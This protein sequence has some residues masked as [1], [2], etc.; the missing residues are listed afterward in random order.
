MK[1][2]IACF[3]ILILALLMSGCG[4][5]L[6]SSIAAD[7]SNEACL[8]E[9]SNNLDKGSYDSVLS[10]SCADSLQMGAAYLGK[11]GFDV[12]DVII[13]LN[14]SQESDTALD[15]YLRTV[16]PEVNEDS[17]TYLDLSAA[18][19]S[20][21]A[22]SEDSYEDAQLYF[23]IV[24]AIR[25]LSLIELLIDI[26]D[27]DINGNNIPDDVDAAACSLFIVAGQ[28]CD[29]SVVSLPVDEIPD[30][31]MQGKSGTY[32]GVTITM[33][34]TAAGS[35]PETYKQIQYKISGST[36]GAATVTSGTCLEA[37][38][39]SG[40]EWPCPLETGGGALDLIEAFD[41]ALTDGIEALDNSF[42]TDNDLTDSIEDIK[43][44]AC[45]LDGVCTSDDI[46]EYLNEQLLNVNL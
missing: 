44:E 20:K 26:D 23:A 24:K 18:E 5:N 8:F 38:P 36:Y 45:G 27:C 4:D 7:D 13:G 30:M 1:T 3:C 14:D 33:N 41:Q 28:P 34:G 37:S 9:T 15:E 16:I 40:R 17:L 43:I 22:A 10:S 42:T 19:Y 25:S 2:K 11:A 32:K 29:N 31:S 46:A 21:V 6:F 12:K 39:V 35:C